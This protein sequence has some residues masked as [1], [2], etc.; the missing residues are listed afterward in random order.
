[1][2]ARLDRMLRQEIDIQVGES[3]FWFDSS[4]VLAYIGND[5]RRFHTFVA[6][7]V[8]AI[9]EASSPSQWCHV[10]SEQNPTDD[11]SRGLSADAL[12]NKSRWLRGPDFLWQPVH[13]WP[14]WPSPVPEGA[15]GDPEVKKTTEVFI[16]STEVRKRS[17]NSIFQYFSS[18]FRLKTFFA[19]MLRFR[20]KLRNAVEQRRTGRLILTEN[21]KV[22]PITPDELESA[23]REII[24]HVQN[25]SFEEE[26]ATLKWSGSSVP[27]GEG[28][29]KRNIKKSSKVMN[30][31]RSSII[32]RRFACR[33]ETRQWVFST[34]VEA[35]YDTTQ[36]S[37]CRHTNNYYLSLP[38]GIWA[39]KSRVCS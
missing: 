7:H 3:V 11:A 8:A 26:V 25:E 29:R 30:Q 38:S 28:V 24:R 2:A 12:T 37:S 14:I 5:S 4:C 19:W 10:S 27:I 34:R 17:M 39:L 1:M 23:G 16:A 22:D 6:N 36:V 13:T 35:S 15:H 33:R 9:Q 31:V 18:W 32:G 21:S 20:V